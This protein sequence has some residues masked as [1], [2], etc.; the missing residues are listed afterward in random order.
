MNA[1][2]KEMVPLIG[3]RTTALSGNPAVLTEKRPGEVTPTK[4]R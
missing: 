2:P 1:H 3:R 4:K